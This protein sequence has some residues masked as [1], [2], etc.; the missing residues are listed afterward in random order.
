[1]KVY[2]IGETPL[3]SFTRAVITIGSFDG[4]HLGHQQ[5]LSQMQQVAKAIDGETVIIT[6]YPHPRKIVSSIPG[7]VKLL[8]TLSEKK[9]LLAAAGI[10]HLVVVPFNHLF[11]QLSAQ[12][13]VSTFLFKQFHPHTIIIGYDHRFGK[14]RLGDYQLLEKMGAEIG[15]QVKEIDEQMLQASAISSTRIRK[16]LLSHHIPEATALLGYPYFFEG[17]VMKGNQ[18]GR[19]IGFPTANLQITEEDKLIP[20]NGVYVVEVRL[21]NEHRASMGNHTGMMNIGIRP[22]VDGKSRVIEVHIFDFSET[23]YQHLIQVRLLHFL[24][25]EIRFP[26][27]EALQ[28]QLHSDKRAALDWLEHNFNR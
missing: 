22:T 15:F 23:I 13:F 8:T 26:H 18:L 24:R 25:D 2:T 1:M 4:V 3:P 27:F 7:D 10:D 6:F 9:D 20:A 16:A 14:G 12:D 5:I 28:N 19:T 17:V 21:L 11:A